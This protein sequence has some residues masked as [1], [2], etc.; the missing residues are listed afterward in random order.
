MNAELIEDFYGMYGRYAKCVPEIV[1]GSATY[2]PAL[3][4]APKCIMVPIYVNV[5]IY[6]L[7]M[8]VEAIAI[9]SMV[10]LLDRRYAVYL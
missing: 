4:L 10:V 5:Q 7:K 2:G 9:R 6:Q 1:Y 8:S 3:E